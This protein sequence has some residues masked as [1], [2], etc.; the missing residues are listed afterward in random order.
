LKINSR[1]SKTC[2]KKPLYTFL[3]LPL[4]STTESTTR[5]ISPRCPPKPKPVCE[6][7]GCEVPAVCV[8]IARCNRKLCDAHGSLIDPEYEEDSG[9]KW[10]QHCNA[11]DAGVC[12]HCGGG[13]GLG[14]PCSYQLINGSNKCEYCAKHKKVR[15]F[16]S[17]CF[18]ASL[19]DP[20]SS[21]QNTESEEEA[22]EGSEEEGSEE[23]GAQGCDRAQSQGDASAEG[24]REEASRRVE[25]RC[26]TARHDTNEHARRIDTRP[27]I[28]Y[29]YK[30]QKQTCRNAARARSPEKR[31]SRTGVTNDT[32]PL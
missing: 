12:Q 22:E 23:E 13:E 29:H 15:P 14:I 16:F 20:L 8:C 3:F 26:D 4:P 18:P 1:F 6:Y 25:G 19:S 30:K 21:S 24:G 32:H 17:P 11:C 31:S 9:G 5:R 2:E 7:E 10:Y 28:K 27:D